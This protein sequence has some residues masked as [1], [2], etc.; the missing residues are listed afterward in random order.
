MSGTSDSPL[1][2]IIRDDLQSNLGESR[3]TIR[4]EVSEYISKNQ[5][6]QKTKYDKNRQKPR[7]YNVGDLIRVCHNQSATGQSRKLLPKSQWPYKITKV[8]I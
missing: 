2:T 7:T 3:E 4:N 6:Y 5:D 1:N 8:G